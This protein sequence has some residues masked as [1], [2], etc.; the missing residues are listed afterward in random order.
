MRKTQYDAKNLFYV[1]LFLFAALLVPL[2]FGR[3]DIPY[4]SGSWD[5]DLYGNHRVVLQVN[6]K[7]DAV[8]ANV[9]W[10]RRDANPE[11]K[12]AILIDGQTEKQ[13]LNLFRIDINREYGDFVFQPTSGPGKYFLYYFHRP[14]RWAHFFQ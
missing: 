10:R 6:E 13:V 9:F 5:E 7:A 1:R 12:A 3:Q 11:Q 8:W 2:L 14:W 4:G